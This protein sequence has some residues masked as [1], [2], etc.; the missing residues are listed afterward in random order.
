[1][2]LYRL[3]NCQIPGWKNKKIPWISS[4]GEVHPPPPP[5]APARVADPTNMNRPRHLVHILARGLGR[6]RLNYT[7]NVGYLNILIVRRYEKYG[8]L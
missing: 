8:E 6:I 2:Q 1:M 7:E 5:S 4:G 3:G